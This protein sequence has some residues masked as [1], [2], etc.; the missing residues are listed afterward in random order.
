[1]GGD[2]SSSPGLA[3]FLREDSK[4]EVSVLVRLEGGGDNDVLARRQPQLVVHLPC[5]GEDLRKAEVWVPRE[6]VF[7]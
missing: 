1:M 2:L 4:Q 7:P 5:G 6:E 3:V